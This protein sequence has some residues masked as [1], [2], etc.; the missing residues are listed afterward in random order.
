MCKITGSKISRH[1]LQKAKL[2]VRSFLFWRTDSVGSGGYTWICPQHC[3]TCAVDCQ[4]TSWK[5]A[6]LRVGWVE[7]KHASE[8]KLSNFWTQAAEGKSVVLAC[9]PW[10][11]ASVLFRYWYRI[12]VQLFLDDFP[13]NLPSSGKPRASECKTS[14]YAIL[15]SE[16][17]LIS[18][19]YVLCASNSVF[20][21][22]LL[23]GSSSIVA[24]S[25][26]HNI[27]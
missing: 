17:K 16:Y 11:E 15:N 27:S 22:H 14:C 8:C 19:V 24:Q 26:L 3:V 1:M 4:L 6:L 5:N 25:V 23:Y 9:M 2:V 20:A 18:G 12:Q 21:A 10:V 7:K 13:E